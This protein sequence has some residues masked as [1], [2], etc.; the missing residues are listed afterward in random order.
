MKTHPPFD[1][2]EPLPD[3]RLVIEASAGTGKTFTIAAIVT[4]LVAAAGIPLDQ[5]LVVTFTRAAT[6]E[7]KDRIRQRMVVTAAALGGT[8]GEPDEHLQVLLNAT[9]AEQL[10]Y[11]ERLA[12]ALRSYDRAQIFTIHGFATR[13]LRELGFRSRLSPDLEPGEIDSLLLAETAG[14]LVV[15]RFGTDP[16]H[17]LDPRE[18]AAM[19]AAIANTPDARVVPDAATAG[20]EAARRAEMARRMAKELERRML[21]SGTMT[22]DAGLVEARDALEDPAVKA[23]ALELLA[24]RYAVA[25]VDESQDTDPVQWQVIRAVFGASRLV[26]IGDPKQSIYAFRGA[27]VESYL[28]AVEAAE[29]GRTLDTNWRSDGP[30][31]A[32]LDVLFSGATFGDD[33]IGYHQVRPAPDHEAARISGAGPPVTVHRFGEFKQ[34][35]RRK[36]GGFFVGAAREAVAEDVAAEIVRLLGRGATIE[37]NP[38]TRAVGPGDI[39]VLC[40]TRLQVEMVR[41]ALSRREVPSV[42]ARTG[43]VFNTEAAE[44]WRRFLI[45]VER[46]DRNDYVRLAATSLLIGLTP[47]EV[48]ELS[49]EAALELQRQLRVWRDLLLERGVPALMAEVDR[50]TDLASRVLAQPGGERTI[51]DIVH[52]AEEMHRVFRRGRIGSLV[53]WLGTAMEEADANADS[54]VEEPESRQRRLETDAAAVQ[55]QTIH[56]AKGLEYPIVFVPFA[57]DPPVAPPGANDVPIFHEATPPSPGRPRQRIIDVGG[58]SSPDFDEHQ[59]AAA[60]EDRDEEGRLLYVALTRARHLLHIWWIENHVKVA[61]TKLHELLARDGGD[62]TGLIAASHGTIEQVVVNEPAPLVPYVAGSEPAVVLERAHLGRP[63][64]YLWRRVSFSSLSPEH[65]VG[66]ADEKTEIPLRSDEAA[67]DEAEPVASLELPMAE[68]PRGAAFGSLVHHVL[69]VV[70]LDSLDLEGAFAVAIEADMRRRGLEFD[71][72]VLA[73]GLALACDTPLGVAADA[74]TL[75][76]LDPDRALKEMTFELPVRTAGGAV[77]LHDVGSVMLEHLGASDPYRPYGERLTELPINRFRGYMTG[78]IDFTTVVPD[79]EGRDRYIVMDYKS[80]AFR[81]RG[82]AP[83]T[84]DYGGAALVAA[85]SEGNYVLQALLYQVALHRYLQWRLPGYDPAVHLG[86]S[87]YLFV[88]GMVGAATP[89]VEG[90]RCGVAHWGPPAELVVAVSHLFSGEGT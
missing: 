48:A 41:A 28:A 57:W 68:L 49:E 35:G 52:I 54:G 47:G 2:A 4:R 29:A 6:A 3:G 1:P 73:T 64:D 77:S 39:A 84:A 62:L 80:N 9:A 71:P 90:A 86:G 22:Y 5:I 60:A 27:D 61:E 82:E 79:A 50:T 19:G 17:V 56:A 66:G 42:A 74:P 10:L 14:D 7:L 59:E 30:L 46:P 23:G 32:A 81:A 83:S 63:L 21:A 20:G 36:D 37:G 34:L 72:A 75:H 25:L 43:S 18:V 40:R 87:T 24:A 31:L 85:M 67:D 78:A 53:G 12:V 76:H 8:A 16:D 58:K 89:V 13:L 51:T 26:V 33:R 65:P 11:W 69:E 70:P 44:A 15:G 55:V 45:A 88:R 38:G